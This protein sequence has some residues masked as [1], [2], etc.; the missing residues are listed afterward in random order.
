MTD[1][2]T[3]DLT[4]DGQGKADGDSGGNGNKPSLAQAEGNDGLN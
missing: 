3:L 4:P 2:P 1:Q